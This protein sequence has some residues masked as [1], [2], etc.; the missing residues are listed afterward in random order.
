MPRPRRAFDELSPQYRRRLLGAG[1]T[2]AQYESGAD[3]RKARGHG[4]EGPKVGVDETI[5]NR[6][7]DGNATAKDRQAF[8][9][10]RR[11]RSFPSW[12]PD[13][14]AD[15]D[16]QTAA[17]LATIYP[18]PDKLDKRGRRSGWK[19]VTFTYLESGEVRMT[20]KPIH[21]YPFDVMLPDRDSASQ[22]LSVISELNTPG[23]EVSTKG[24]GYARPK[25]KSRSRTRKT[26]KKTTKKPTK[27]TTKKTTKR[28]TK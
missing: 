23:I 14:P 7:A 16:D 18:P 28:R 13:D 12:I 17:L 19:S 5:Q 20:V 6:I 26:T 21:G 10:A 9:K 8:G 1:V 24:E 25:K 22:V 3:L 2:K 27:K 11:S 4:F 15:V